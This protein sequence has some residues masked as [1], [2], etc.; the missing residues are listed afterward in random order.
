M[1]KT[2]GGKIAAYVS[3]YSNR[4]SG[5]GYR[6]SIQ[7]FLRCT[8]GLKLHDENKVK[9]IHDYE[10]LLDD[11]LNDKNRKHSEDV[12]AFSEYLVRASSSKQSARQLLT[13]AAKFLRAQGITVLP[14]FIQDIK[15]ETKGGSESIDE[16]LTNEMICR[17]LQGADVRN[18]AIFLCAASSGLRIGEL[19]SLSMSDINLDSQPVRITVRAAKSKNKHSRF[20]FITPEALTAVRAWLKVKETYLVQS[21]KHN[22]NLIKAGISNPVKTDSDLLFPVSDSQVNASWEACLIKAGLH[23][24]GEGKSFKFHS[25]RKFF[26]SRLAMALP[27]KL[28]QALVGHNGYLD[29]S[30]LRITPEYAAAEYL[31]VQDVLTCC[32]PETVKET[33][34]SLVIETAALKKQDGVQY[35]SIEY[36]RSVNTA[37]QDAIKDMQARI[38]K[39]ELGEGKQFNIT[40]TDNVPEATLRKF[41]DVMREIGG[42]GEIHHN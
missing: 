25:L 7:A 31:K 33:I 19:L 39:I 42:N 20:T 2:S 9:L 35:E 34:K 13:Y 38:E 41:L 29:S 37:Q 23:V 6:T 8:Y 36:L 15:R 1:V 40:L 11:Y 24:K 30:Y 28:V 26:Y 10:K 5:A 21:S 32:V 14:E 22:R 3:K 17:I 16:T 4:S 27:E 12:K 18:R